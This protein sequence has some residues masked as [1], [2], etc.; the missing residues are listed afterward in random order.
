ME[1]DP[2][3]PLGTQAFLSLVFLSV[4]NRLQ[5]PWPSL[6]SKGQIQTLLTK[7]G[8]AKKPSEAN[9]R[10]CSPWRHPNCVSNP[11]LE[12]LL[13]NPSPNPPIWGFIVFQGRSLL[14]LPLPG[15]AIKLLF[16]TSPKALSLRFYSHQ[17]IKAK[18]DFIIT[19]TPTEFR[20]QE[21]DKE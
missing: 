5:P 11:T 18:K 2:A 6:S 7:G 17:C 20:S 4:G 21:D 10:E 3:E 8:A 16:S 9:Q 15:K 12:L 13:W 1:H 14:W 19:R